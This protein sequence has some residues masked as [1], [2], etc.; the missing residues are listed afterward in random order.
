[1]VTVRLA[2]PPA[3]NEVLDSPIIPDWKLP[4]LPFPIE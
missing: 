1:M 3:D 2:A 4:P